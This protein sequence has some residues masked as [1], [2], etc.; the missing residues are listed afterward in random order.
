MEKINL[1]FLHGFLGRP[2]DWDAVKACLPQSQNIRIFL[3]DFFNEPG[4][5]PH[6]SFEEWAH[7]FTKWV[8]NLG[9]KSDKNILI[10]YSL[11]G[12]LALHAFENDPSLWTRIICVSTNPGF[13][14]VF[15]GSAPL[16]KERLSRLDNDTEWS[17]AFEAKPW[18]ELIQKWN[19]QAVFNGGGSEP[20]RFEGD[21]RRYNLSLALTRWSLALQKN[22]RSMLKKHAKKIVWVVGE[23][24]YKF[25]EISKLLKEEITELKVNTVN[26]ASHRVLFDNP[27]ELGDLIRE[28]LC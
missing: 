16:S 9:L 7:N 3:P 6:H 19:A 22:M 14:D 12:R 10:G 26:K 15:D 18:I 1:F 21:Y 20:T 24:D 2:S 28:K 17:R 5:G 27:T 11:G 25:V 8:E 13:D 4:L 23:N